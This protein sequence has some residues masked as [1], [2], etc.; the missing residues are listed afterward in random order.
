MRS[1]LLASLAS[2]ATQHVS[3]HSAHAPRTLSRRAVDLNA[4]R[5]VLDTEYANATSVQ[6]DPS[7]TSLN[8]RADPE[9]TATELVKATVSLFGYMNHQGIYSLAVR[10]QGQLSV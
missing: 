1:F 3:A 5:Q 10:S 7:I 9:D 8:K 6:S 2:L 4:F